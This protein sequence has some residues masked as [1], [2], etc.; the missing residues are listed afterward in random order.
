M[1]TIFTPTYN[2]AYILPKLYESLV[3]QSDKNFEW[4]I[5]D[6]G[7]TDDTNKLV[8]SWIGENKIKINYLKTKNR[9]KSSAINTGVENAEGNLFFIVDS[10]DFLTNDAV[11][12]ILN[13]EKTLKSQNQ[14]FS[15]FVAGFCYKKRNYRTGSIISSFVCETSVRFASSLELAYEYNASGDKAEIFYTD[16]LKKFPFPEIPYNKF[17]PEALVWYRIAGAGYKFFVSDDA[18]YMCD[19]IEDGY[20]KNFKNNLK[21]NFRGFALFYKE[22]L[23][24]KEIPFTVKLKFFIRYV[25]CLIY[26]FFS[27][28]FWRKKNG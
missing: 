19:Y 9:G 1:I 4:L 15:F 13:D 12:K 17:V 14:K 10:D 3:L 11:E 2:R 8:D 7:S 20:T 5:V 22:C 28:T 23:F 25:Q 27:L 24:Y 18:I 16:V 6:D 26:Q 21:K